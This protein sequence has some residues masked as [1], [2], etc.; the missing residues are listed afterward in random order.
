[1]PKGNL[2]YI[3]NYLNG[4]EDGKHTWYHSNGRVMIEGYYTGGMK[5]K[6][7][8]FYDDFGYNYLTIF[9]DNDIEIKFQGVKLTP[10]YEE[11]LIDYSALIKKK[12]VD[13][14]ISE[15]DKIVPENSDNDN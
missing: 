12:S 9:Y 11:S 8:K 2:K 14:V 6:D 5:Q 13:K 10:T 4:D 15:K 7:W 1:M 3:G